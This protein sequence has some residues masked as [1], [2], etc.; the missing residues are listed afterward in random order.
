MK[1]TVFL[2]L[3]LLLAGCATLSREQCQQGDWFGIGMTDGLGGEQASRLEQHVRA[4]AEYGLPVDR[5]HYFAGRDQGLREYCRYANA[6]VTGLAGSRYQHVCPP[7]IDATFAHYNQAAYE[8]Y[9]IKQELA[10]V[11]GQISSVEDRLRDSGLSKD[12]RRELRQELRELDR[13]YDRLRADLHDSQRYLEHLM[14]E[15][16]S[17]HSP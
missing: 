10:S 9:R 14:D 2:L 17:R 4:C 11:D 3:I 7:A 16:R 12:R 8:V 6:F 5:Q 13:R 1:R 15:S